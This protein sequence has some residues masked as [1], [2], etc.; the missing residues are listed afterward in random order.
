[1][2]NLEFTFKITPAKKGEEDKSTYMDMRDIPR[3]K[4]TD[5]QRLRDK[6]FYK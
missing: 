5:E 4:D 6:Y 1:M 2:A 3:F